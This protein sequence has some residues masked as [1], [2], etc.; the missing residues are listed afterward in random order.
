MR[1]KSINNKSAHLSS[2]SRAR[3]RTTRT[4]TSSSNTCKA[5]HCSARSERRT[6]PYRPTTFSMPKKSCWR[7]SSCRGK[8]SSIATLNQRTF[9]YPC[10]IA[11]TL[12]WS[13]SASQRCWTRPMDARKRTAA[14]LPTSLR[15]SW[16][17]FHTGTR[18]TCGASAYCSSRLSQAKRR[19][20]PTT[21][22]VSTR[23]SSSASPPTRRW[24][25]TNFATSWG[26]YLYSIRR[27]VWSTKI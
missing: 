10:R 24:W 19:S 26:K 5:A 12:S 2:N 9:A 23:T 11:V 8:A 18:W 13:T 3:S 6:R 20:T 27:T 21:Q 25:A 22:R 1:R 14:H 16:K 17:T 4:Y 15:K 7:C